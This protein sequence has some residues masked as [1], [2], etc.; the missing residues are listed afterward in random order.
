MSARVVMALLMAASLSSAAHAQSRTGGRVEIS[1][2][3]VFVGGFDLG[4][5][6]AQL[7][8]NAGGTFDQ[9]STSGTVDPVGGLQARLG[10]FLSR[11]LAIE[12]G[13]RWTRPIFAVRITGDSEDAPDTTAEETL[14][15]YLFDGS[16]VLHFGDRTSNRAVPFIYG[17][18]GYLRELHEGD[19]LVE[20]GTEFHAGGGVKIWMGASRRVGVRAE[21]GLSVR[22]GGFDFQDK[23]R[24]VPVA[25]G[26]V[27]WVF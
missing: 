11:A 17:G 25:G 18:A 9:F 21:A 7:T 22:D 19:A 10:V 13:V 16:A 15:Q 3:G 1:G 27:F 6:A 12:G 24:T 5:R 14:N 8:A 2:G 23:R 20:E 26:F 4:D